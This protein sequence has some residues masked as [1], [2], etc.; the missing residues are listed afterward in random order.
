MFRGTLHGLEVAVKVLEQKSPTAAKDNCKD[1]QA[2]AADAGADAAG[3]EGAEAGA[4]VEA[5]GVASKEEEELARTVSGWGQQAVKCVNDSHA[6]RAHV[7]H[8]CVFTACSSDFSP[9]SACSPPP[10][11]TAHSYRP[12]CPPFLN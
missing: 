7:S 4:E 1:N 8:A 5:E 3:K 2:V 9:K 6:V 11:L 12:S 10:T